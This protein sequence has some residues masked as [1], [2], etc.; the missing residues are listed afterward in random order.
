M[1]NMEMERDK[2]VLEILLQEAG[3]DRESSLEAHLGADSVVI[4][5]EKFRPWQLVRTLED[6]S[7]VLAGL[8]ERFGT[9]ARETEGQ[10]FLVDPALLEK[11]GIAPDALLDIQA[12]DGEIYITEAQLPEQAAELLRLARL[13]EAGLR[14]LLASDTLL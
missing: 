4:L 9:A 1:E 6:L 14:R 7:E 2:D 13:P 8:L 10:E 12:Y 11:A 3:L 5:R